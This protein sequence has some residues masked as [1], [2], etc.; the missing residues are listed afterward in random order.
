MKYNYRNIFENLQDGVYFV[1]KSRTIT[2]W[3]KSAE[4]ITGFKAKDVIGSRCMDNIL[5]HI[6]ERN[7]SLCD[8]GCPLTA[9]M[10]DGQPR[11]AE[12]YLHHKKGHRVPVLVRATALLD[13]DDR[14][15]GAAEVFSDI[16]PQKEMQERI[17]ELEKLALV[18][19]LTGLSNRKHLEGE[20]D[21]RFQEQRR[22]G[23]SFGVL[24]I[25]I[26]FFKKVNDTHG[27]EAGDLALKTIADTFKATTRSYDLFGRWGG[28]EF[29]AIVRNIDRGIL[30]KVAERFRIL[31]EKTSVTNGGK[32][33]SVSVSIGATM[34]TPQDSPTTLIQRADELMYQSKQ[35][36]RN[37]VTVDDG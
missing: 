35:M 28:E 32:T 9:V 16:T 37:R 13:E 22:Y 36:G 27:H 11:L 18:D 26:D 29:V 21:A 30:G 31:V 24:F 3:N 6:N 34:A 10:E 4:N 5:I 19:N 8:D 17:K 7:K 33:F 14:I 1:D 23:L 20:L 12:V 15:I 2:Y 25:D